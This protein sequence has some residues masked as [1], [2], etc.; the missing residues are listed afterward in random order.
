[1]SAATNQ[2][3]GPDVSAS[4]DGTCNSELK[5]GDSCDSCWRGIMMPPGGVSYYIEEITKYGNTRTPI[6]Q[7]KIMCPRCGHWHVSIGLDL[8]TGFDPVLTP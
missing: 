8:S 2:S 3:Q 7:R 4:R 5:L 1:M 6:G